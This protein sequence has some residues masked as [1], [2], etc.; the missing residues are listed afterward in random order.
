RT[1]IDP[2]VGVRI[3]YRTADEVWL[4]IEGRD[5]VARARTL[6]AAPQ[7]TGTFVVVGAGIGYILDEIERQ[8]GSC[9]AIA[10]EPDPAIARLLLARRDWRPAFESGRLRLLTGPDFHG[11]ATCARMIDAAHPAIEILNPALG[12]RS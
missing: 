9:R 4:P 6:V 8:D 1:V 12:A 11:A 3:D 7:I 5:P 10:I 2:I